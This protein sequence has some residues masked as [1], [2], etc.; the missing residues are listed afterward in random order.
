MTHGQKEDNRALRTALITIHE[1]MK[2][3]GVVME[4]AESITAV[5]KQWNK[6]GI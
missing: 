4:R 2:A 1:A 3:A 6:D 5:F